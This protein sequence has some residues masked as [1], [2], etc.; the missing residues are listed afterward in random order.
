M[1]GLDQAAVKVWELPFACSWDKSTAATATGVAGQVARVPPPRRMRPSRSRWYAARRP[2]GTGAGLPARVYQVSLPECWTA[3]RTLRP[4]DSRMVATVRS[5]V[6]TPTSSVSAPPGPAV[7]RSTYPSMLGGLF[8]AAEFHLPG[9][10][11]PRRAGVVGVCP[12][13]GGCPERR[14]GL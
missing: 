7:T 4:S 11:A 13:L 3:T 8:M 6:M 1:I 10:R 5:P 2:A 12:L 9:R 14:P